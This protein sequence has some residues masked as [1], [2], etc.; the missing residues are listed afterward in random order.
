MAFNFPDT[1]T[2]GTEY[3]PVGGV[4]YKYSAPVWKIKPASGSGGG[5]A[6]APN[7]GVTY[8]RK[9]LDWVSIDIIDAGTF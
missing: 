1:P 5:I 3:T 4:T 9:S 2:E 8:G 7:D 6:E